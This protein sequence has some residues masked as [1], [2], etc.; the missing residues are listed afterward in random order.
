[1]TSSSISTHEDQWAPEV[2]ALADGRFFVTWNSLTVPDDFPTGENIM[3]DDIYGRLFNADGSPAG[4]DFVVNTTAVNNQLNP[5]VAMLADGRFV[6]TWDSAEFDD[7]PFGTNVR[8]RIFNPDG[9]ALGGDFVIHNQDIDHLGNGFGASVT[10]LPDGSFVVTWNA[11]DSVDPIDIRGQIYDPQ[12]TVYV[13]NAAANSWKGGNLDDRISGGAGSDT[14]SGLGGDDLINGDFGHDILN[15]GAGNDSLFGGTGTDTIDGGTGNDIMAGNAGNDTYRVDAAGDRVLDAAGG[16]VDTVF[17][18]VSYG[19]ASGAEVEILRTTSDAA[20]TAINLA[21]NAF[22]NSLFG[23]AGANVL[24]GRGG[25]DKMWGLGGNDAYIVDHVGDG[26]FEGANLGT[27]RVS[28][29]VSFTLG[30][31]VENMT[32]GRGRRHQRHRQ[33]AR[34]RDR[35]QWRQ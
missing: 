10:A 14:L 9:S 7:Y 5:S 23:N 26:V 19:L 33:R 32:L 25:A 1:M 17:T 18:S 27:D 30:A 15:G 13:G 20:T 12:L 22:A 21:G 4:N 16:G 8:A 11:E 24:N 34:Q 31:N 29:T 28:T 2:A 35:W 3:G 6:V